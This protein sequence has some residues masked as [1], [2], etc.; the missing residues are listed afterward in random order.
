MVAVLGCPRKVVKG[1]KNRVITP[2]YPLSR[3]LV[4]ARQTHCVEWSSNSPAYFLTICQL[5]GT[6]KQ[7]LLL[8]CC[9][10]FLKKILGLSPWHL[11]L[12]GGLKGNDWLQPQPPNPRTKCHVSDV[13]KLLGTQTSA[14]I[15]RAGRLKTHLAGRFWNYI[16]VQGWGPRKKW[17]GS[18]SIC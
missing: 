18:K 5:P 8:Q 7:G 17:T 12:F 16:N 14:W 3:K 13:L 1:L 9:G 6:S 4:V 15:A 11:C 2:M 10:S